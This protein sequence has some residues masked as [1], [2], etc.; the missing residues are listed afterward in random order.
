MGRGTVEIKIYIFTIGKGE[1]KMGGW[2][3]EN[4]FCLSTIENGKKDGWMNGGN[5]TLY[6]Y[7]RK[8]WKKDG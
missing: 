2:T 5:Q 1:K 3:V 4:K 7:Y 6:I 8:R